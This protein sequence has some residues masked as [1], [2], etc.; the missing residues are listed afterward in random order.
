MRALKHAG[1]LGLTLAAILEK[2]GDEYAGGQ[3]LDSD[4]G[5]VYRSKVR[6]T[7]GG[8]KLSV[9]GYIGAPLL[10]RSLT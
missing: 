3:I 1:V 7:D 4:K 2:A 10:G 5:K 9:R 8:K 6:L